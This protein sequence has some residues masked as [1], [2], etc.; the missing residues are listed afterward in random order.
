MT[1]PVFRKTR[2]LAGNH[3]V[4]RICSALNQKSAI[5]R[6]ST[7][8]AFQPWSFQSRGQHPD[9]VAI[10]F[11]FRWQRRT[12]RIDHFQIAESPAH[13]R[14]KPFAISRLG[15]DLGCN[16]SLYRVSSDVS[17]IKDTPGK[18]AHFGLA[19]GAM[20]AHGIKTN[21]AKRSSKDRR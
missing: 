18:S 1:I 6:S 11:H 16:H 3:L 14:Q 2:S 4:F 9:G 5:F 19:D 20:T 10:Q 8:T 21:A 17:R 15:S 12:D 13:C 7:G